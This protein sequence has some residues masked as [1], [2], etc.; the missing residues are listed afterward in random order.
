[1]AKPFPCPG[2][3]GGSLAAPP[4]LIN[5][6]LVSFLLQVDQLS[7]ALLPENMVTAAHPLFKPKPQQQ[8]A[9]VAEAEVGV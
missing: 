1:M 3:S 7:Y 8:L 9:Q 2:H 4:H 5:F 6:S